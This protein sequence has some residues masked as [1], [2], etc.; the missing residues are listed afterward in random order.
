MPE[1]SYP[2]PAPRIHFPCFPVLAFICEHFLRTCLC[3][4]SVLEPESPCAPP[5]AALPLP[6]PALPAAAGAAPGVVFSFISLCPGLAVPGHCHSS[7][8]G[9]RLVLPVL[10]SL[11]WLSHPLTVLIAFPNAGLSSFS[12]FFLILFLRLILLSSY[13]SVCHPQL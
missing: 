6:P 1:V 11:L 13:P 7:C 2:H 10:S 12:N 5:G 8:P 4:F 3:S 9:L